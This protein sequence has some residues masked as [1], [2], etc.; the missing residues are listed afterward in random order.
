MLPK[1]ILFAQRLAT[2]ATL[3]SFATEKMQDILFF[4]FLQVLKNIGY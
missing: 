1:Q 4:I 3:K 2:W